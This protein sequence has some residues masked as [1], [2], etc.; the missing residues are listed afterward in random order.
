MSATASCRDGFPEMS[1]DVSVSLAGSLSIPA[2]SVADKRDAIWGVDV[3]ALVTPNPPIPQYT[4]RT[5]HSFNLLN[6]F[7]T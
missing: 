3:E 6:A 2:L 1:G 5:E 7:C 4:Q